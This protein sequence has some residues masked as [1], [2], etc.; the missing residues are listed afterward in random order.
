MKVVTYMSILVCL[1]LPQL[2]MAQNSSV[3]IK[4]NGLYYGN[5]NSYE[6]DSAYTFNTNRTIQFYSFSGLVSDIHMKDNLFYRV[7]IEWSRGKSNTNWFISYAA[8]EY[9]LISEEYKANGLRTI[10]GIGKS[11]KKKNVLLKY[12]IQ[13]PFF[14]YDKRQ[15]LKI[16]ENNYPG[17]RDFVHVHVEDNGSVYLDLSFFFDIHYKIYKNIS[18][19][20]EL[21][22]GFIMFVNKGEKKTITEWYDANGI[23]LDR[24][25]SIDRNKGHGVILPTTSFTY[26]LLLYEF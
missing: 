8:N 12:G 22:N 11:Y 5:Y 23:L 6:F 9:Q 7:G 2:L 21:D 19:G 13:L 4:T 25:V 17:G 1:T 3:S 15:S 18:I 20:Y 16:Y 14:L 26:F 24:E 10:I